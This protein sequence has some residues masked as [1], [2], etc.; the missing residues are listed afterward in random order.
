VKKIRKIMLA[1]AIIVGDHCDIHTILAGN[2][3]KENMV[4]IANRTF[5]QNV[6]LRRIDLLCILTSYFSSCVKG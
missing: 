5:A 2:I 4:M 6:L 1:T 3:C